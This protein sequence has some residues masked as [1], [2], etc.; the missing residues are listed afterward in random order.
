MTARIYI[1]VS[2]TTAVLCFGT[3]R[4]GSDC[5]FDSNII[6]FLHCV[7]F[8]VEARRIKVVLKSSVGCVNTNPDISKSK[9]N[10]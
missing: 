5:V 1:I 4:F 2:T 7:F 3:M 8:V 9:N 10:N 6:V